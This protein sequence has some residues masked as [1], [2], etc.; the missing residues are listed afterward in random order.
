MPSVMYP[1]GESNLINENGYNSDYLDIK[2]HL[3]K[4][5]DTTAALGTSGSLPAKIA[6]ALISDTCSVYAL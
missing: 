1:F 6:N 5:P 3:H 4:I 2:L